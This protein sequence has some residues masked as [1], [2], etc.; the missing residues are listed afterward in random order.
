M[1]CVMRRKSFWRHRALMWRESV[2]WEGR[3]YLRTGSFR[4][5]W[6]K[7]KAIWE[8][9]ERRNCQFLSP[10]CLQKLFLQYQWLLQW[11]H[12]TFELRE[13]KIMPVQ[14]TESLFLLPSFTVMVYWKYFSVFP[15]FPYQH[16]KSKLKWFF[17]LVFLSELCEAQPL[18]L[19]KCFT[20]AGEVIMDNWV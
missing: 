20:N 2:G 3:S 6:M 7:Q 18:L 9:W 17:K 19:R 16:I 10:Y 12:T 15:N 1:D 11:V 5:L 4:S 14:T 13:D 8:K